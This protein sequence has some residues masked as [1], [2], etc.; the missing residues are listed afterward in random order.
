MF[1]CAMNINFNRKA[2]EYDSQAKVKQIQA[3]TYDVH[4]KYIYVLL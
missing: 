3:R 1:G 4:Y 2:R